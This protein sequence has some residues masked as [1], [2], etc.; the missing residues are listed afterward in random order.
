MGCDPTAN[1]YPGRPERSREVHGSAVPDSPHDGLSQCGRDR[2]RPAGTGR[3]TRSQR[4]YCRR[5]GRLRPD[6]R[7]RTS[8]ASFAIETN[9]AN[10]TLAQRIPRWQE[11]GFQVS[12]IYLWVRDVTLAI[13]RVRQRVLAG[14]HDI[15]EETIRRRYYLGLRNLFSVYVL[16]ADRWRIYDNGSSEGPQLVE[17]GTRETPDRD[18]WRQLR[19]LA[20][21]AR[22]T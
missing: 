21:E 2:P 13:Q 14:G 19:M 5:A 17:R 11:A 3:D 10:K 1:H 12:V 7:I 22:I 6:E 20:D 15:P 8:G 18:S 9:L 4:R 16:L